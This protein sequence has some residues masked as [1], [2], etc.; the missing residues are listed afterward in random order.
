MK[1]LVLILA[2]LLAHRASAQVLIVSNARIEAPVPKQ[3]EK[4]RP[5]FKQPVP[6]SSLEITLLDAHNRVRASRGLHPYR[7]NP[8]LTHVAD[9]CARF[10]ASVGSFTHTPWGRSI[11]Q[12]VASA[13]YSFATCGEN[14]AGDWTDSS[15]RIYPNMPN[16]PVSGWLQSPG[17]A[18]EVLSREHTEAGFAMR[19]Q[20]NGYR[21]YVA[22]YA[23]PTRPGGYL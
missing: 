15:G 17:H 10:A 3:V 18:R 20:P 9:D 22:V 21:W 12:R 2:L 13:G 11:G 6:R 14:G 1:T 19:R 7:L 8:T 4:P 5:T 23:R 16:D